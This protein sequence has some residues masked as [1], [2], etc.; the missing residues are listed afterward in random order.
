MV[1]LLCFIREREGREG[2]GERE[3]GERVKE[4]KV[5]GIGDE[6][7]GKN[8]GVLGVSVASLVLD[9]IPT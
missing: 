7:E 6:E 2:R 8:F 1:F 5:E 9:T 4:G 3:R